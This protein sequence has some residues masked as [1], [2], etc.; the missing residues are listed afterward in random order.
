MTKPGSLFCLEG[1]ALLT[2]CACAYAALHGRARLFF[3]LLLAPALP[4]LGYLVNVKIG[5]QAHNVAHTEPGPLAG[6][7]AC[8]LTRRHEGVTR[9]CCFA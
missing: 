8:A 9:A 3:A 7:L 4:M 2:V 5:A 1:A 6:G